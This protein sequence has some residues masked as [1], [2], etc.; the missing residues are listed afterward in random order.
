MATDNIEVK[1]L[2]KL[3]KDFSTFKFWFYPTPE[4]NNIFE[5]YDTS[6]GKK[7]AK[8]QEDVQKI[9]FESDVSFGFDDQLSILQDFEAYTLRPEYVA[10]HKVAM[11]PKTDENIVGVYAEIYVTL[12]IGSY[13]IKSFKQNTSKNPDSSLVRLDRAINWL[14]HTDFF[15]APSSSKYHEPYPHGLVEHILNV[16][17]RAIQLKECSAFKDVRWES[18]AFSALCHDLCK[19][20]LYESYLRNQKN[21]ETGEWEKIPS[22]RRK[23][24]MIPFGHGEA[25]LY[26][27]MKLFNVSEDEAL[28]IRWHMARWY[29]APELEGSLTTANKRYPLVHMIQF[30]DQ[31]SIVDY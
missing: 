7:V 4:D 25:S 22:Y 6:T 15:Y 17:N 24:P 2:L 21:E 3:E 8:I 12:L 14:E 11:P 5:V 19:I 9:Y 23:D 16:Y 30:A 31:L 10:V 1:H 18:A 13:L 27:A 26:I 28:A 20:N 29:T